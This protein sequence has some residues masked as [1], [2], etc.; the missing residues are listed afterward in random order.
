MAEKKKNEKKKKKRTYNVNKL[1]FISMERAASHN[2]EVH[3]QNA[4]IKAALALTIV[5]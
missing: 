5:P 3:K 1:Q 4:R 2:P